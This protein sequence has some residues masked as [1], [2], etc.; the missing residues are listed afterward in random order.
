MTAVFLASSTC[1]SSS[2]WPGHMFLTFQLA[3]HKAGWLFCLL[4]VL[5]GA[6][7]AVCFSAVSLSSKH[8]LKQA[9]CGE[10]ATY[11]LGAAQLKAGVSWPVGYNDPSHRW[12]QPIAPEIT[13]I[14]SGLITRNC[15]LACCVVAGTAALEWPL[16]GASLGRVNGDPGMPS[17]QDPPLGLTYVV[18]RNAEQY[19]W[20]QLG[21]RSCRE[22]CMNT[23]SCP[24]SGL[25]YWL[26][27]FT[28]PH[29]AV[30][31]VQDLLRPLAIGC[32]KQLIRLVVQCEHKQ[33]KLSSHE[34]YLSHTQ[35]Y[36]V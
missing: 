19:V 34:L 33:I 3:N 21:C 18:Q 14:H 2:E 24:P 30:G 6:G 1:C 35:L 11:W 28:P 9:D 4:L 5:P 20:H 23:G 25:H 17:R 27:G 31:S 13:P 16:Q 15:R 10:S 36:R 32:Q 26:V 29:S 7:I 12:R 8:P 22:Q